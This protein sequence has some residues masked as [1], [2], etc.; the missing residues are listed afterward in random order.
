MNKKWT[1]NYQ[2]QRQRLNSVLKPLNLNLVSI[3]N[4]FLRTP[5]KVKLGNFM[6]SS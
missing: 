1:T 6:T 4:L 5:E 3:F 2:M